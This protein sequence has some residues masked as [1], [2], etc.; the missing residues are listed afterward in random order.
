MN[1]QQ[2]ATT[3]NGHFPEGQDEIDTPIP[4]INIIPR[5]CPMI[6]WGV[7]GCWGFDKRLDG[8]RACTADRR[9]GLR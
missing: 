8:K 4:T 7:R 5:I 3:R 2:K 6:W 1:T 9:G